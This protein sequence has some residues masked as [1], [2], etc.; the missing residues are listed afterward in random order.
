MT[1]NTILPVCSIT[2]Q[3]VCLVLAKILREPGAA[4]K[5]D[6]TMREMLPSTQSNSKDLTIERLARMQSGIRDYWVLTV[7]WGAQP[8]GIFTV[9]T[10][11]PV[12][13]QKLGKFHFEPGAEYSYSN[14]N[15]HILGRI[16]ERLAAQALDKLLDDIFASA[17]MKAAELR[18]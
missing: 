5:A 2:K 13:L 3:F 15:C 12:A 8:D 14:V 1:A 18:S 4:A 17:G 10:D 7:L 11:A 9:A 16:A 6:A